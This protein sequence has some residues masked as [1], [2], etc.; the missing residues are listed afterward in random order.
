MEVGREWTLSL[1]VQ[2]HFDYKT[3]Q[4]IFLT[5]GTIDGLKMIELFSVL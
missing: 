5:I 3:P 1:A 4:G 2:V